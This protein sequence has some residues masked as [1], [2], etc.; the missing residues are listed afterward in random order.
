M[1]PIKRR[2]ARAGVSAADCGFDGG[3]AVSVRRR[4]E[5]KAPKIAEI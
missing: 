3:K 4:A 2:I 1:H 5:D